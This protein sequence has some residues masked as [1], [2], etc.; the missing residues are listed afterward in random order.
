[1]KSETRRS[2][3]GQPLE[4]ECMWHRQRGCLREIS[5]QGTLT[6]YIIGTNGIWC[7]LRYLWYPKGLRQVHDG[8]QNKRIPLGSMRWEF[9]SRATNFL[10]GATNSGTTVLST[11]L[12]ILFSPLSLHA[13][14][15][16]RRRAL[17]LLTQPRKL[18]LYEGLHPQ[19]LLASVCLVLYNYCPQWTIFA[20]LCP[21]NVGGLLGQ[22]LCQDFVE[23][24][25]KLLLLSRISFYKLMDLPSFN[26]Y[27]L[28]HGVCLR[29]RTP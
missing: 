29:R 16:P 5:D 1:M 27:W 24:T 17:L 12:Q 25:S 14:S 13:S 26:N 9:N 3:I 20:C 15:R 23:D 7:S 28:H 4:T 8:A 19:L 6:A 22:D 11:S 10:L 18:L 2:P 21:V